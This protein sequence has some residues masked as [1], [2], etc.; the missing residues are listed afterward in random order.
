MLNKRTVLSILS[1]LV[2]SFSGVAQLIAEYEIQ[3]IGQENCSQVEDKLLEN[4]INWWFKNC[5]ATVA[6]LPQANEYEK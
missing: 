3:K 4:R 6:N 1:E 5:A 2:K